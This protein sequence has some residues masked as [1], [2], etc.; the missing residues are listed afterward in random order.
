MEL[1][2]LQE[3]HEKVPYKSAFYER[4][5]TITTVH[6]LLS[7]ECS[8]YRETVDWKNIAL[9]CLAEALKCRESDRTALELGHQPQADQLTYAGIAH[10]EAAREIIINFSPS[11]KFS[12]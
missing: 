3:I 6:G 1:K 9:S 2:M 5:V 7:S 8:K 12:S 10:L 4:M 11:Q